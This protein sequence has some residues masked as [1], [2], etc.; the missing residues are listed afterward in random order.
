MSVLVIGEGALAG[1]ACRQLTSEG[2]SVTH[3]GKAGD[4]ELSA[5]LDGGVSAVAVLLHD[6]TSAIRYVLAVEH[7]RPGMRI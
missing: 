1:R 4:R 5:A 3:L 6:D 2:H 7:L